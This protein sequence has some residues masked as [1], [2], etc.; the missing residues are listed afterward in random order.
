MSQLRSIS[1]LTIINIANAFVG[2]AT[3]IAMAWLFGTSVRM[4]CYFSAVTLLAVVQKGFLVGQFSDNFL[5]EYVQ[6]REVDGTEKAD[7]CFSALYNHLIFMLVV[8]AAGVYFLMPWIGAMIAPGF[9]DD[10]QKLVVQLSQS[11]LPIMCLVVANGHLQLIGNARGWFGRFEFYGLIGSVAGLVLLVV[12]AKFLGIWALMVSQG[13]TQIVLYIGSWSYLYRQGYR[14]AWIW[15]EPGF[16]V[17][18]VVGRVGLSSLYVVASQAFVF[19][20]NAA[21]TTLPGGTLAVYKYA[22]NLYTR[23]GTY[24]MRPVSIVFFTDAAVLANRHPL[25]LRAR[26]SEALY[27][28]GLMYLGVLAVL[29]PALPN[30]L[31]ALWGSPLYPVADIQLTV[32]FAWCFFGLLIVDG[33][34]GIYRRLNIIMGDM[35]WVYEAMTLVQIVMAFAA[36]YLVASWGLWGAASVLILNVVGLALAGLVIIIWRRPQF[37]AFFPSRTWKLVASAVFPL[38]AGWLLPHY[39]PWLRYTGKVTL[40]G[41]TLSLAQATLLGHAGKVAIA[42]AKLVSF[43]QGALL[44]G[45]GLA[46]GIG[47]AWLVGVE[48]VQ[49]G[50]RRAFAWGQATR[51]RLRLA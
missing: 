26:I 31:G 7:R 33:A 47:T 24:F 42:E 15:S 34:G 48:E 27:Q 46:L 49:V 22:E 3:S 21:L 37:L 9:T 39:L 45:L 30:L 13:I 35:R 19:A 43:A 5:P 41:Q 18:A 44:G 29:F 8:L 1:R 23:M 2:V 36:T 50:L 11:F 51:R 14:H 38:L 32:F 17:W 25:Q 28:Y 12:T 40:H 6:R 16:S 20:F 4:Q 10:E